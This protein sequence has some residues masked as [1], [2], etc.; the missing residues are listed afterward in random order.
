MPDQTTHAIPIQSPPF[1]RL[2]TY[3]FDPSL[4]FQPDTLNLNETILRV[5][6]EVDPKVGDEKFLGPVGEY[7]EIVNYD[8]S[9]R[10]FYAPVDLN[11][12]L[13]LAQDGLAPSEGNPQFHQQMVYAVAMTTIQH[14]ERALGRLALS[15]PG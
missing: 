4:G 13:L 6:W 12:P 1:R 8:P 10:C 9:S 14:F 5:A 2:R 3:A 11:H 15:A 7:L